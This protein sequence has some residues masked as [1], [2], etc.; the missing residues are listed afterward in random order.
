MEEH[1]PSEDTNALEEHL[2]IHTE[3]YLLILE[4]Y[5]LP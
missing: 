5:N 2:E 3:S 1:P 4:G